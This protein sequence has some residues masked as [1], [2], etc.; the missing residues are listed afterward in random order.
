MISYKYNR[1]EHKKLGFIKLLLVNKFINDKRF[2]Y[3]QF[4]TYLFYLGFFKKIVIKYLQLHL[5]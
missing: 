1:F 4:R 5:P 2:N 3:S